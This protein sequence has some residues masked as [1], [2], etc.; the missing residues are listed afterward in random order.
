MP[1]SIQI[2]NANYS[3]RSRPALVVDRFPSSEY[4]LVH[5]ENAEIIIHRIKV[6]A[7]Q[8]KHSRFVYPLDQ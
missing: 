8:P 5:R 1:T 4:F 6:N 3:D 7:I 2:T